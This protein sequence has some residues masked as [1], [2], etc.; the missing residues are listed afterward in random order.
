MRCP[1]AWP[2]QLRTRAVRHH[3]CRH[4]D[5]RARCVAGSGQAVGGVTPALWTAL[6]TK[7]GPDRTKGLH[8]PWAEPWWNAG[9]RARPRAEGRRKPPFPWRDPHA[10]C[11][12]EVSDLRLPAFRFPYFFRHCEERRAPEAIQNLSI[13]L[14]CFAPLAMTHAKRGCL[15]MSIGKTRG[16]SRRENEL[17][18]YL[19][20]PRGERSTP[21]LIGGG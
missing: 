8:T 2:H 1:R 6:P 11:V 3:A 12:R 15:T 19:S 20:P 5:R 17:L 4:Y 9:R 13:E 21:D 10:V 14:D 16:Q 18:Y 7:P